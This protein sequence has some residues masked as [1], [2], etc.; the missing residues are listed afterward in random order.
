[1]VPLEA[2]LQFSQV[3][4]IELLLE[5]LQ[6]AHQGSNNILL[7]GIRSAGHPIDHLIELT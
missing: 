2:T 6:P 3:I 1:M 5:L 7:V 4:P